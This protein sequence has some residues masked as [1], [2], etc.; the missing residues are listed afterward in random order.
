MFK[1]HV[2]RQPDDMNKDAS[3]FMLEEYQQIAAAYFGLRD[4]LNNWFRVYLSLLAVPLT[5][6]ALVL[7]ITQPSQTPGLTDLPELISVILLAIAVLG[8]FTILMVV[9]TRTEMIM[10]A[11][12]INHVRKYF[13]DLSTQGTGVALDGYLVLPSTDQYPRF[14]E[15]FHST[16]IMVVMAGALNG[17]VLGIACI[18][19]VVVPLWVFIPVTVCSTG[20]HW[21]AYYVAAW[22]REQNWESED[23][24]IPAHGHRERSASRDAG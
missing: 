22:R 2:P 10:Y 18:N 20:V 5:A 16:F 14:Y 17:F 1:G 15:P 9:S 24:M 19:L 8:F 23:S 12:T 21:A 3:D 7:Q 13:A 6:L 4:Q 11:R